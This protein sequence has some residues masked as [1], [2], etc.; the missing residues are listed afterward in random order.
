[1]REGSH[2]IF[3][4]AVTNMS[5]ADARGILMGT[6]VQQLIIYK[7]VLLPALWKFNPIIKKFIYESS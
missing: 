4:D 2:P 1:M 6:K 7:T 5:F 3:V